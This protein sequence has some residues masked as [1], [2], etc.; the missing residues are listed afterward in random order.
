MISI[1]KHD[2]GFKNKLG[3]SH[4]ISTKM[5]CSSFNLNRYG[6]FKIK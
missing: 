6:T 5:K 1:K 2:V 4:H 3:H